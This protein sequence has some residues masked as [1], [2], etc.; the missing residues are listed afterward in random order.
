[1]LERMLCCININI[2][3]ISVGLMERCC[4]VLQMEEQFEIAH[5]S[6]FTLSLHCKSSL[7]VIN[8]DKYI[9]LLYI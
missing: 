6:C 7:P 5:R 1:M 8:L 9:T 4:G 2:L 3:S